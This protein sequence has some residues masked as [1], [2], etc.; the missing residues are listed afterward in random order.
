ML[1]LNK[2]YLYCPIP[3][4]VPARPRHAGRWMGVMPWFPIYCHESISV[5]RID[6]QTVTC[7][8]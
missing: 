1:T 3:T 4:L 6:P 5:F 8:R 7:I 2:Y